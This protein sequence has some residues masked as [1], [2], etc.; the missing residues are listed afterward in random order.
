MLP[1][2]DED[3]GQFSWFYHKDFVGREKIEE[4]YRKNRGGTGRNSLSDDRKAELRKILGEEVLYRFVKKKFPRI[5]SRT[6]LKS[7]VKYVQVD[8]IISSGC[9]APWNL[10]LE[11]KGPNQFFGDTR[12]MPL[13]RER[14]GP[15]VWA[16]VVAIFN[17]L[18]AAEAEMLA[19]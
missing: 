2:R 15:V 14:V 18:M 19:L 1:Y 17:R 5:R 13:K 16:K 10:W 12:A 11:F 4:H 7:L 3:E 6:I 9:D 8:H